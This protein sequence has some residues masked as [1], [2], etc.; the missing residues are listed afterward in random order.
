VQIVPSGIDRWITAGDA[1]G[2][3][4]RVHGDAGYEK[5]DI[6]VLQR[7][8]EGADPAGCP[9]GSHSVALELP[10]TA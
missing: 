2:A 8:F 6:A 10:N 9:A 1:A 5:L 7:A 3:R 4:P